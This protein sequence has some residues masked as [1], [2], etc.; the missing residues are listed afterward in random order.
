MASVI[1]EDV[2]K[3]YNIGETRSIALSKLNMKVREGELR[4]IVGP[5]GS[6]KTTL[7]NLIGAIDV[8]DAGKILVDSEDI[9]KYSNSKKI[10]YRLNK[11]GFVFQFFNLLPYLTALENVEF[12]MILAGVS[13]EVRK[14]RAKELLGKVGL[15]NKI[16]NKP[17]EL[18]GGEQQR[19]AIAVALANDPDII[20]ADEPTG[21]LDF[22]TSRMIADLFSE[23]HRELNKT[24]II[25]THDVSLAMYADRISILRSGK[26]IETISPAEKDLARIL[27]LPS[28]EERLD[29]E[30]RRKILL[31]EL[32]KIEGDFKKGLIT[33]D[34]VVERYL[35]LKNELNKIEEELNKISL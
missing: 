34:R 1:C 33:L 2:I 11:V 10:E 4:V 15:G 7:L 20:L 8:P 26:I 17:S 28:D 35:K 22:E 3:I 24:I 25:A 31:Q 29:L 9:T 32:S 16:D 30:N 14:K 27:L 6:G 23:L 18:S 12:P 19:V 13:R 5:S 21:E